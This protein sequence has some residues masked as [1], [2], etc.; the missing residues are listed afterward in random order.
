MAHTLRNG[1]KQ[2]L[3]SEVLNPTVIDPGRKIW[4]YT[5]NILRLFHLFLKHLLNVYL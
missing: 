5:F 2:K 1:G 3:I 4:A